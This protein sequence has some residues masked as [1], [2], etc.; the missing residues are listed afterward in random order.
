MLRNESA[1]VRRAEGRLGCARIP[2]SALTQDFCQ[3]LEPLAR[4]G[5]CAGQEEGFRAFKGKHVEMLEDVYHLP[6]RLQ[7]HNMK[8]DLSMP[9][10]RVPKQFDH[11]GPLTFH[12]YNRQVSGEGGIL[13][14]PDT[15]LHSFMERLGV[16]NL[17]PPYTKCKQ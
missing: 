4:L 12:R 11:R 1:E 13:S 6:S 15:E 7:S 5:G 2:L 8:T 3:N 14:K 10:D 9:Q 17:T 16:M